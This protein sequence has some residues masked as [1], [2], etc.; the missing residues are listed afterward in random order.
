M[1]KFVIVIVVVMLAAVSVSV[2]ANTRTPGGGDVPFYAR[3]ESGEI[4]HDDEWAVII[5]YR[6][7]ECVPDD[8]DLLDFYDWNA[9]DCGP[10]TTD[11]FIIWEGEPGIKPIQIKLRGL[12]AVPVWFVN[13]SD[14]EQEVADGEL[15]MSELEAM[16]KLAGVAGIFSETLHPTGAA[17][18]PMI[19]FLAFGSL[20]DGTSFRIHALLVADKEDPSIDKSSNVQITFQ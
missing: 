3:I 2:Y 13:W 7:T 20:E 14:L 4:M 18:V 1:K 9:F 16:D 12:G 5:F 10:P 17:Q 6:P 19:N 8:F 11:G 15:L